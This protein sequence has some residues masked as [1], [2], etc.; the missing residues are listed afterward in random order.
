MHLLL[1]LDGMARNVVVKMK[2]ECIYEGRILFLFAG[3]GGLNL[4]KLWAHRRLIYT[5]AQADRKPYLMLE[6]CN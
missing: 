6:F 4:D 2:D 5:F 1:L 3:V